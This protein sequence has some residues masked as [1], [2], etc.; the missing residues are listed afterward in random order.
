MALTPAINDVDT[1]IA[2]IHQFLL[3]IGRL[4]NTVG[5]LL[6]VSRHIGGGLLERAVTRR[7]G[8]LRLTTTL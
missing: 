1:K 5:V 6:R 2:T 4:L 8:L 3:R 7:S